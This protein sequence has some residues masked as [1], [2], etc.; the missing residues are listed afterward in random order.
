MRTSKPRSPS[1]RV[2]SFT[3]EESENLEED[4]PHACQVEA[5]GRNTGVGS[6][7]GSSFRGSGRGYNR[8]MGYA[9]AFTSVRMGSNTIGSNAAQSNYTSRNGGKRQQNTNCY[10]CGQGGHLVRSC[11]SIQ[12][13]GNR[14]SWMGAFLEGSSRRTDV[15][16]QG[17]EDGSKSGEI[18][19]EVTL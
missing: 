15:K 11:P 19:E 8:S 10:G 4:E 6:R 14:N 9:N 12:A 13:V 5:F 17:E 2:S 7:R 1:P 18:M 16:I 3:I